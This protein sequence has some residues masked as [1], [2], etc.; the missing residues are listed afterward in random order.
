MPFEQRNPQLPE[1]IPCT[2]QRLNSPM[3]A[4]F[5]RH[6]QK[7]GHLVVS[8]FGRQAALSV[9]KSAGRRGRYET[10]RHCRC[11]F[12]RGRPFLGRAV[13]LH[14]QIKLIHYG[15]FDNGSARSKKSKTKTAHPKDG[16][17]LQKQEPQRGE[18]L[19]RPHRSVPF[20]T[21]RAAFLPGLLPRAILTFSEARKW[22]PWD[23]HL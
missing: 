16:R 11:W 9:P 12:C 18:V 21:M 15:T 2:A 6:F 3:L 1:R 17:P 5:A 4:V 10:V 14:V 22:S 13:F 20:G 7:C 23:F 8:Q 19:Q